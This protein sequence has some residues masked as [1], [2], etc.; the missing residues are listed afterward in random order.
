[1]FRKD[2]IIIIKIKEKTEK[3]HWYLNHKVKHKK[4]I[5]WAVGWRDK[6]ERFTSAIKN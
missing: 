1:M 3:L 4:L 5:Y 2:N 6:N